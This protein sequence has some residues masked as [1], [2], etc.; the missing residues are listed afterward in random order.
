MTRLTTYLWAVMRGLF[1]T[2]VPILLLLV[3]WYESP[4]VEWVSFSAMLFGMCA[5]RHRD[6]KQVARKQE[7]RARHRSR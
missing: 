4:L 3:I 2:G 6:R 5:L 1:E 7:P